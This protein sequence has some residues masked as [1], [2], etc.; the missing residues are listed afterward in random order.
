[1]F[2]DKLQFLSDLYS[3]ELDAFAQGSPDS[4][5]LLR[6]AEFVVGQDNPSLAAVLGSAGD[7]MLP[8]DIKL[9]IEDSSLHSMDSNGYYIDGPILKP[10][11]KDPEVSVQDLAKLE[12][13]IK[14]QKHIIEKQQQD[15]QIQ[16]RELMMMKIQASSF[17]KQL[18][19][20]LSTK[21]TQT[22]PSKSNSTSLSSSSSAAQDQW[23]STRKKWDVEGQS[24]D[25]FG[26]SQS[27]QSPSD[28]R[29]RRRQEK[30]KRA[31]EAKSYRRTDVLK[32][33]FN[34]LDEDEQDR[35]REEQEELEEEEQE[36]KRRSR[37]KEKERRRR[38]RR[39]R[40]DRHGSPDRGG[41]GSRE[42]EDDEDKEKNTKYPGL[43][44]LESS[45]ITRVESTIVQGS[46]SVQWDDIAGLEPVKKAIKECVVWPLQNP[47]LFTG[48]R[49]PPRG[50]LLFGPPGTGKTLIG[51]AIASQVNATF[52][53]LS[54]SSL[55]SK[56]IGEGEAM[57]KALFRKTLIGKAIASQVNATFFSL[58]ASSLTSKWIGEGE[59]MV[60]AL[61]SIA[62]YCAPSVIFLDEID[63]LLTKRSD[64][65]DHLLRMKTEFLVQLDGVPASSPVSSVLSRSTPR[66]YGKDEEDDE[67]EEEEGGVGDSHHGKKTS[68]CKR[69]MP[70]NPLVILVGATNRPDWI[71]EAARRRLAGRFYIPLPDAPA[72][73]YLILS[74]LYREKIDHSL[75][76]DE[77]E[78]IVEKTDGYSGSDL[79]VLLREAS[80]APVREFIRDCASEQE[81]R[82]GTSGDVRR[83]CAKDFERSLAIVRPSVSSD[84]LKQY[85]DF[86]E[87]FGMKHPKSSSKRSQYFI[88]LIE[89]EFIHEGYLSSSP[90]PRDAPN[91]RSPDI[92]AI[93]AKNRTKGKGDEE[94]DQS[95]NAQKMMKGEHYWG[96]FTEISLPFS[97]STP[98]KGAY[99]C[100][101]E[102]T[103][104]TYP[105]LY[106]IFSLTSSKGEKMVKKYEFP[107]LEKTSWFFLPID[108]SDVV[109][110]EITGKR[111]WKECFEIKSLI[112]ISREETPEEITSREAREKLWSEAPVV[113]PEFVKEGDEESF[114]RDSI[115]IPRDDPKLVDP[116]FSMV[117][118][119]DDSK[120]K[121]SKY[122]DQSSR[123]Q[124]MLKGEGI[125]HLSHL[126]IPFPSPSPMKGAYI[127]VDKNDSSP[128]LLF[129]FTDCDG[130]K[131]FKK[132]EFTRPKHWYEWLFLPIDLD[133]VVLCEI[134]GKR[135]WDM[136]NSRYFWIYSLVFLRG[137]DI[138]TSPPLLTH[139]PVPFSSSKTPTST[140]S[141]PSKP[142]KEE[143]EDTCHM[144]SSTDAVIQTV[145]PEFI[146]KGNYKCCPIPR[147]SPNIKSAELPTIEAIDGT[148]EKYDEEYDQSSEAQ[149]MMKGECNIGY[150]TDISIPF[151]SSS[152]MK[153]AYICLRGVSSNP[154]PPS[155][156]IFTL[157]SSKGEKTSK[158]Y[159]F[160]EVEGYHWHFLPVDLLDIVLCEIT[161]EGREEECF[162]FGIESI[163]FISREETPEEIKSCEAREKLWSEAPVVKPEFVKEGWSSI[164]IVHDNP[165]LED[166]LFS[167]VKLSFSMVKCKNDSVSKE[168]EEYD[169]SS[170]AQKML[171]GEGGVSLS[172]LS[173]P[174][175]SPSPMKGAY[176]CVD[177]FWSSPFLL[178]TFTDCDGK[179]TYKKYEFTRSEHRFEWHFLPIDLD[180]V[181]LCEIEGK[182]K[183]VEE[184][185]RDFNIDSLEFLREETPEERCIRE[186]IEEQWSKAPTIKSEFVNSGDA[187][188]IPIPRDNAAVNNPSFEMVKGKH[189]L[190]CQESKEYDRSEEV[191]K[192]LKCEGRVELSHL[193]IPFPSPSPMKGAYICVEK[194]S[195]SPSLRFTFTDCDGKKTS[196]K[197]E[198]IRPKHR[199]EWHF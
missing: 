197:Y 42:E 101:G 68:R 54:A 130:K 88:Q 122:Y 64:S 183:W 119:K 121:E 15:L 35:V 29:A 106:L 48:M 136:K 49:A 189:D 32:S 152:P 102:Y 61:F 164:R 150:F 163:V 18:S 67:E 141:L 129:T 51:K 148:K 65:E 62:R 168:S 2:H 69:E 4:F 10:I 171:K 118:C 169:T 173:I 114:G 124:K 178:F 198:F 145:Q 175:P 31:E 193:S 90:I 126:S 89:P 115:P 147:D 103:R 73:K 194:D 166:P 159:E 84:E 46:V 104:F 182:G 20:T 139:V 82:N 71:D 70:E 116:S 186:S 153:G 109:L 117:K 176:I 7:G 86:D 99:I 132:Y 105:P 72:R 41:S 170:E 74:S 59:A 1:M 40:H 78:H 184:N 188:A 26:G 172:H 133:N 158:I 27:P 91:V 24:F 140:L 9:H 13:H 21:Q 57:V 56:W 195:S 123:A 43:E 137:D 142:V 25:I 85:V 111:R 107:E 33:S 180:N 45:L 96:K 83:V 76:S 100:I 97:T 23:S 60:K 149:M 125:V 165:E 77:I 185:S 19:P 30:Q 174:F 3:I 135:T 38:E 8:K 47:L 66:Y 28:A 128:S 157:I 160:P 156:L 36:E 191:Q 37:E 161:G 113:N 154:S 155:H 16:Q 12:Q 144:S 143:E 50:I 92:T 187:S 181:V 80:L 94:Y 55:T 17:Q 190:Y 34:L 44:H 6:I 5:D 75:T 199:F 58:S 22:I 120:S 112:F 131:T 162:G 95:S 98:I 108:L 167:I 146:H 110:C 151:S 127:C 93:E 79:S 138:P 192:M 52:F 179:K 134:E 14:E 87:K 177:K 196:K 81:V 11:P 53:S 63:S 39:R